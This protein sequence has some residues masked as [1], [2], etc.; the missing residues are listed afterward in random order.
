MITG[1]TRLSNLP[2]VFGFFQ[3]KFG[4]LIAVVA[5]VVLAQIAW[6]TYREAPVP[7]LTSARQ[8][9]LPVTKSILPTT[10]ANL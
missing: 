9:A 6:T 10:G 4:Q 5:V 3:R 8:P 1:V 2:K 7:D